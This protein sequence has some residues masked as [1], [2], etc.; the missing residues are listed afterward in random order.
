M[1]GKYNEYNSIFLKKW[2]RKLNIILR[3]DTHTRSIIHKSE[4]IIKPRISIVILATGNYSDFAKNLVESINWY[5]MVDCYK[6]II[7][8]SDTFS[9]MVQQLG[10]NCVVH[11]RRCKS[12]TKASYFFELMLENL[13]IIS[14]SDYCYKMDADMIIYK[15]ILG[16]DILPNTEQN[17]SIVKHFAFDQ[18]KM[19]SIMPYDF[20]AKIP[21]EYQD[22]DGWQ[23]CL[24]GGRATQMVEL[25]KELNQKIVTDRTNNKMWGAWEEPYVNWYFALRKKEVRTLSPTYATPLYW[26]RFP[27]DYKEVYLKSVGDEQE[28]IFHFNHTVQF[29]GHEV[30]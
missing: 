28:K 25:A 20:S 14:K 23:S 22:C 24:F 29:G 3:T 27:V 9:P 17:F 21:I 8:L 2:V 11:T 5:F 15:T 10:E 12:V 16:K 6:D 13:D 26:H 4:E 19:C 18:K 30:G 1:W 7:L